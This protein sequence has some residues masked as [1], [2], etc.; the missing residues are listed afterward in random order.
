MF[1][2][3]FEDG[4]KELK[5]VTL[6]CAERHLSVFDHFLDCGPGNGNFTAA[7]QI[8]MGMP[9]T[10]VAD[11]QI[12]RVYQARK[13]GWTTYWCNFDQRSKD[14]PDNFFDV[15]HAGQIIEHLSDTD[16]FVRNIYSALKTGGY[17]LISTPNLASWHNIFYLM[18]G[19]QPPVAMV[20]DEIIRYNMA[21]NEVDEPKHRRIFTGPGLQMLLEHH[22]FKVEMIRGAGYYPFTGAFGRLLAKVD[23]HHAAYIVIKAYKPIIKPIIILDEANLYLEA[24]RSKAINA[25][26]NPQ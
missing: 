21:D 20:S 25:E 23:R 13:R 24:R 14:Y 2:R 12:K 9:S 1:D 10:F 7:L 4:D 11:C 19:K 18:L 16:A 15:I 26:N 22:G 5:R 3:I 6:D 17:L 8:K